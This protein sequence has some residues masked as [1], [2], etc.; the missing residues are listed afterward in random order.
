MWTIQSNFRN[1]IIYLY[2]MYG[3][4]TN[5]APVL[6]SACTHPTPP[7]PPIQKKPHLILSREMHNVLRHEQK[8]NLIFSINSFNKILLRPGT[9]I[10]ENLIQKRWLMIPD[11]QLAWGIQSKSVRGLGAEPP[12]GAVGDQAPHEPKDLGTRSRSNTI[13]FE[14][15]NIFA[16]IVLVVTRSK[17]VSEDSKNKFWFS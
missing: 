12:V 16:L 3:S 13:F 14:Q 2:F 10:L 5:F 4:I 15:I 7:S 8:K 17:G 9:E 6:E 1:Y 11:N